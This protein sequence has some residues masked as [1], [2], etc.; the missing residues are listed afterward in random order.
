M[1]N[2]KAIQSA[3]VGRFDVFETQTD[4]IVLSATTNEIA[5]EMCRHLNLGG[6][7]DGQTPTFFLQQIH[8]PAQK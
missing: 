7:F 6:G 4:Q 1:M 8:C 3:T 2:Y 5:K